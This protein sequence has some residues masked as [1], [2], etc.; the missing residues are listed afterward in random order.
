MRKENKRT[1]KKKVQ[2]DNLRAP[3]QAPAPGSTAMLSSCPA[4]V[5]CS[6][7]PNFLLSHS[8]SPT[9]LLPLFAY[10]RTPIALL[11]YFMLALVSGSLAVLLLLLV[12][13]LTP[14]YL[15]FTAL[16]TFKQALSN[17]SLRCSTNLAE[18]LYLFS[19]LGLLLAKTDR[20]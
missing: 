19:L 10:L 11:S 2:L 18:F 20:K 3:I 17:K 1:A 4:L 5:S 8:R 16:R 13:G 6:R 14:L 15:I 9:H 7:S 12:L